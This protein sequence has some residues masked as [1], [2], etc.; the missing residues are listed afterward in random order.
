MLSWKKGPSQFKRLQRT[1]LLWTNLCWQNIKASLAS[2]NYGNR[3]L[4]D[5][6][7]SLLSVPNL[8]LLSHYRHFTT[9]S[10]AGATTGALEESHFFTCW[11]KFYTV[12]NKCYSVTT[13][14]IFIHSN[15]MKKLDSSRAGVLCVS[16]EYLFNPTLQAWT[17][18]QVT[19]KYWI[20]TCKLMQ[21]NRPKC[22]P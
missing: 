20:L 15:N 11:I 14:S 7:N 12:S 18:S 21:L 19:N 3:K 1:K 9:I 2:P 5:N 16:M 8:L 13:I 4:W 10:R 6:H 22:F 17:E